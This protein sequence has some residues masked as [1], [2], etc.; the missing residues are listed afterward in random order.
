MEVDESLLWGMIFRFPSKIKTLITL[1][2]FLASF[3]LHLFHHHRF[4]PNLRVCASHSFLYCFSEV[5]GIHFNLPFPQK[6]RPLVYLLD[7]WVLNFVWHFINMI[8]KIGWANSTI[9]NR[10]VRRDLRSHFIQG[11]TIFKYNFKIVI[12][13]LIQSV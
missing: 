4:N 12:I 2:C 7:S 13:M 5:L 6:I 10:I 9:Q 8:F 3:N 1:S 11:R